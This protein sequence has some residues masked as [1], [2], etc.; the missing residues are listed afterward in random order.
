MPDANGLHYEFHGPEGAPVVI[1]SSGLGGSA[2]YWAPNLPALTADYRVLAYDHRGTGRSERALPYAQEPDVG[3]TDDLLTLMDALALPSAHIIGHAAGAMI[4]L[5]LA[6]RAPERV[7]SVVA[8]NG[9]ATADPHFLRC[10]AAR[11]A[12]LRGAGPEAFLRAQPIFLYPANWISAHSDDLERELPH[13]LAAFPGADV[14]ERR[15]AALA[16]FDLSRIAGSIAAPV[17]VL[18]SEDDMLVP[19]DAGRRL[20]ALLPNAKLASLAW[21]GHA[22]NITD[23]E[24]FAGAILPFLARQTLES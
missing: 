18:V 10:F 1:L 19:S 12:I 15:I 5:S 3:M 16:A 23:P 20:A 4:G 21:G 17:L 2:S 9:W 7:R 14:V 24:G 13:Q 11:M 8:I 22:V 6:A